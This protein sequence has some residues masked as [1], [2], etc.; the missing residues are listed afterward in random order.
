[1]LNPVMKNHLL[2][3][4][5]GGPFTTIETAVSLRIFDY[6]CAEP[7]VADVSEPIEGQVSVKSPFCDYQQ[8]HL[9]RYPDALARIRA[10]CLE[11]DKMVSGIERL[12]AFTLDDDE[13]REHSAGDVA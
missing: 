3:G 5:S 9:E 1:M 12:K 6:R 7:C 13:G 10:V 11:H 4:L 2:K 8:Y